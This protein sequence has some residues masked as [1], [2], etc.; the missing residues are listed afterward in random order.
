M[1]NQRRTHRLRKLGIQPVQ[2]P[3]PIR[4]ENIGKLGPLPQNGTALSDDAILALRAQPEPVEYAP[5][6]PRRFV[7]HWCPVP[8]EISGIVAKA[9]LELRE[10]DRE[11]LEGD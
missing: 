1:R 9:V 7:D 4:A 3:H 5:E 11:I 8:R 6:N 2:V 10:R